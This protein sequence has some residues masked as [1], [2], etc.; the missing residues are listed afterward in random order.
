MLK[1]RLGR[2]EDASVLTE[3]AMRSKAHWPYDE[4]FIEDCREDLTVTPERASDG[5]LFLGEKD[6]HIVGFFAFEKSGTEMSHLFVAPEFIGQ[7]FGKQLWDAALD[8]ASKNGW[9]EF[10]IIADHDGP[11]H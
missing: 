7:G 6:A 9:D 2:V 10:K 5:C 8:F 11:G 1:L 3:L 4:S